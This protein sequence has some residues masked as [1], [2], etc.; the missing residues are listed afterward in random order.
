[1]AGRKKKNAP[2]SGTP[3]WLIT[4][5]DMMTLLLTFF[6]LLLSMASLMDERKKHLALGSITETF[7]MGTQTMSILGQNLSDKLLD[8]G[9]LSEKDGQTLAQLKPLLFEDIRKDVE[10]ISNAF[11]QIISVHATL[12]FEEGQ[13]RLT[14]RGRDFLSKALPFFQELTYP[15]LL[16]GHASPLADGSRPRFSEPEDRIDPSWSL[17]LQ[18]A[19]TVYTTLLDLGMDPEKLR[20]E[21]FGRYHP[22]FSTQNQSGRQRNR[23]VDFIVDKRNYTNHNP[24]KLKKINPEL[25]LEDNTFRYQG[26]KFSLDDDPSGRP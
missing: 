1:M 9:P 11:V 5:S 14:P 24:N 20:L 3:A 23:R 21:A 10:F 18:R 6:V 4:F 12:L 2:Q 7:G 15:L 16:A 25:Q 17:S 8:P 19:L 22:R 13:S 26:F